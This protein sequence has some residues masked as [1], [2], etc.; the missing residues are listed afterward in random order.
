MAVVIISFLVI[1]IDQ[2][3]KFL[4]N[5]NME[6]GESFSVIPRVLNFYYIT[7]DGAAWGM[8]DDKRWVFLIMSTI[9]IAVIIFILV[10]YKDLHIMMQVPLAL[11]LGGGIGNMIDRLFYTEAFLAGEC[12]FFGEGYKVFDGVVIDFIEAAF[13]DFPVFN[14]ADCAVTIGTAMIFVY[15]IFIDG[16]VAKKQ[17]VKT[18]PDEQPDMS[19]HE[20]ETGDGETS[21]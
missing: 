5:S 17:D 1:V 14:V 8:L 2:L 18:A 10:K 9:A 6:I 19:E 15:I 13:I 3:T 7:N 21:E 4:V 12:K 11:I 20:A 16:K